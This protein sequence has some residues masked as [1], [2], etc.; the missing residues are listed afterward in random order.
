[1]VNN[2][3]GGMGGGVSLDRNLGNMMDPMVDLHTN[4]VNNR[5]SSNSNWGNMSISSM[6]NSRSSIGMMG[7]SRGGMGNNRSSIGSMGNSWGSNSMSSR[8]N[9]SYQTMAKS[10]TVSISKNLS[11]SI[12]FSLSNRGSKAATN[13]RK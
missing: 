5:G 3:V 2:M 4:L 9:T 6:G 1:M 8:V 11:I 7:N 13:Q 10:K 12:S